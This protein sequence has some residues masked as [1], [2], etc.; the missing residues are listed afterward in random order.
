MLYYSLAGF[1]LSNIVHSLLLFPV[2]YIL[3]LLPE[4]L[5]MLP[6]VDKFNRLLP[7]D[8]DDGSGK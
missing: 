6:S 1:L 5:A 8:P 3:T 7:I 2:S 4:L